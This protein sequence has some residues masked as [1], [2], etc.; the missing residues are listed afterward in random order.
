MSTDIKLHFDGDGNQEDNMT[1]LKVRR[2]T[3]RDLMRSGERM[4][5]LALDLK[6]TSK[7]NYNIYNR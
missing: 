1:D 6:N 7:L 2:P 4:G 5:R 3:K